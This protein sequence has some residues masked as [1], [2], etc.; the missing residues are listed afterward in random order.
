MIVGDL[1]LAPAAITLGTRF[2]IPVFYD[3]AEVYPVALHTLLPHESSMLLRAVRSSGAPEALERWVLRRAAATF[4]VSDESYQRCRALG[5]PADRLALVGNTPANAD[6]L[7]A[8]WPIPDDIRDLAGRPIALFVGNVF[9]DRGLRY[10]IEAMPAVLERFPNA[11]LLVVGDGRERP[12]L[13]AQ[14]ASAGLQASVRFVGW[15]RPEDLPAYSR[16]ATLGLLPF[17][18]TA[19]LRLTLANK[20]F[21][22]M[23]AGLPV[24]ATDVRPMRRVL[25]E[26]G[27]GVLTPAGDVR[28]IAA[29][30]IRLFG[31]GTLAARFSKAGLEAIGGRYSWRHDADRFLAAVERFA[32]PAALL[33][34][35]S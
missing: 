24:I 21:D 32:A 15:K 7:R 14:V 8:E 4:V 10:A 1:P 6:E 35:A 25:E 17:V 23:A 11:V 28:A 33:E 16:H 26:T 12:R 34:R 20:L 3:M 18:D 31:D 30:I 22:Y 29:A 5:V 27:A 2:G 9:G 13:E 19:H